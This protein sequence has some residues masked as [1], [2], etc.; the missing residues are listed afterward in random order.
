MAENRPSP[1]GTWFADPAH[2]RSP[3]RREILKVGVL[4]GVGLTLGDF[5]ML[6]GSGFCTRAQADYAPPQTPPADSVIQIFLAGGMSHID[7][8][9]P[10]P[11][12]A[13]EIRGELGAVK[14]N[15]GEHFGG[16]L[17]QTA[18]V[19]DK[20]A[21]IRSFTHSEAAHERGTHN[22]LTGHKPSPAIAYPAMG[23][24]V[25]HECGTRN[26]LPPYVCVPDA[27]N[28][29]LGTGYLSSAYG[30]FSLGQDPADKNFTVRDL[31][32]PGDIDEERFGR[33]R[34][35]LETVDQHFRS[36]EKAEVLDA[37]DS[38]YQKAYGL[39]SSKTAREA[40]DIA[41]E[42]AKVRDEYGRH[43]IGQR[44]LMA[45]RLVEAGVRFVTVTYGGWDYHKK[46][47]DG[48]RGALPPVDQ[49]FAALIRD[50]D[51]RGLL[52]RTLVALTTEFGRTPRL[53]RDGGRDHWPKVFSVVLAGGGIAGGQ[54]VGA[55]DPSGAEPADRPIG[56]ADLA[57]T[58]FQQI[59]IDPTKRLLSAGNRPIDIVRHGKAIG[60]LVAGK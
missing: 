12:A 27:S 43:A 44:L 11:D 8:F 37:M 50:L 53:N 55:S 20:L 21:V 46:I 25:S 32:A 45:R 5:L 60:E 17:K 28:P 56:P 15:T 6:R 57:A 42:D 3:S 38:F 26:S 18:A 48:M 7:S 47:R 22:M 39:I 16:L 58:I 59:G 10:K 9:D 54:I 33:R 40:F 2:F 31:A 19:A 49:A 34:S 23:A 14:T 1:S 24:V 29:T 30:P 4:G 51:R 52:S 13:V 35:L 36:L 41:A